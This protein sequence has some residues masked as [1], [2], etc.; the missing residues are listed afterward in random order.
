MEMLS[1]G[2]AVENYPEL[3]TDMLYFSFFTVKQHLSQTNA[4]QCI[5]TK[6]LVA[7]L[8]NVGKSYTYLSNQM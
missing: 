2:N 8:K 5:N 6:E 3:S 7:G 1:G 4:K